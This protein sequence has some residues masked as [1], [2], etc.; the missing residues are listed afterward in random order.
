VILVGEIRDTE[1]ADIAVKAALTGHLVLSTLHTNSAAGAF[2]R[3][4][5]MNVEPFLIASSII[6]VT[7]Q[8]LSRRI[9]EQCKEPYDIPKITIERFKISPKLLEGVTPF[10]GRGCKACNGTGYYGRLGTMEGLRVDEEIRKIVLQRA[11]SDLIE[12]AAQKTG[13]KTLFQN[14]MESFTKGLTTLEEVLRVTSE[15]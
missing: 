15:D 13:M 7:A 8:R 14:A 1:T 6:L 2:T 4:I 3:L 10:H 5:D 11:S 9:C 12:Q